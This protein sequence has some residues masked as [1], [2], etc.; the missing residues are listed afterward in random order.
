MREHATPTSPSGSLQNTMQ[1]KEPCRTQRL[2]KPS[3]KNSEYVSRGAVAGIIDDKLSDR[4][5]GAPKVDT[6]NR[7]ESR[8][9]R[10]QHFVRAKETI[11]RKRKVP[12]ATYSGEINEEEASKSIRKF[13]SQA[14]EGCWFLRPSV[15]SGLVH[16]PV[17]KPAR[18]SLPANSMRD[19]A[20]KLHVTGLQCKQVAYTERLSHVSPYQAL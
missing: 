6:Y 5:R 17:T 14:I 8:D 3:L 1:S 16:C 20:P 12:G 13:L 2:P 10:E 19:I 18:G 7:T 15:L 9:Q 11:S 4:G